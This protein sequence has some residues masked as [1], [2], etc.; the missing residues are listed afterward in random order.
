MAS[1]LRLPPEQF[2]PLLVLILIAGWL[3]AILLPELARRYGGGLVGRASTLWRAGRE[4]PGADR[5][6]GAARALGGC[7]TQVGHPAHLA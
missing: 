4:R 2:L 5:A 3:F 1:L 7:V 6:A